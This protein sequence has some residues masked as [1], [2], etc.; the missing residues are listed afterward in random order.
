MNAL[1]VSQAQTSGCRDNT[2]LGLR[3]RF[4]I[5][6]WK[7]FL[8]GHVEKNAGNLETKWLPPPKLLLVG[9]EQTYKQ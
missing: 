1:D 4:S 5:P 2:N 8:C 6:Q 9:F 7:I 3:N